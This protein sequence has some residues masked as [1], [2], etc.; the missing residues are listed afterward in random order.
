MTTVG[1][2]DTFAMSHAGR[3]IAVVSAFIG[4]MIV[5]VFVVCIMNSLKFDFSEEKVFYLLQRLIAKEILRKYAV[6]MLES[7]YLVKLLKRKASQNP[8]INFKQKIKMAKRAF[9]KNE[10]AFI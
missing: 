3:A 4:V 2:G 5:S 7:A 6:G 8:H 9:S 10:I 1:Y